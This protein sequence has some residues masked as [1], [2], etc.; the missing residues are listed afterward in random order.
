MK[1]IVIIVFF[2][3]AGTSFFSC[4]KPADLPP[5]PPTVKYMDFSVKSE[6]NASFH[7]SLFEFTAKLKSANEN[8]FIL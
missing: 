7:F 8:E 3:F 4:K 2:L 5:G 1:K 6:T